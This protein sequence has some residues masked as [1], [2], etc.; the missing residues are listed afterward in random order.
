MKVYSVYDKKSCS[1]GPLFEVQHDAIAIR[2]FGNAISQE[3]SP[4]RQYPDDFELHVVAEKAL[5]FPVPVEQRDVESRF[6]P[7]PV[8]GLVPV[9]VIT[10]RA[11][12]DSQPKPAAGMQQLS[13]LPE[14]N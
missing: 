11:W 1:Y 7:S 4:L 9:C 3:R 8:V 10:A 6:I 5:E 12:L 2:E 13:L 14:G